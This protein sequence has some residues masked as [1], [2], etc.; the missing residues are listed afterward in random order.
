MTA[1]G[2]STSAHRPRSTGPDSQDPTNGGIQMDEATVLTT[3]NDKPFSP[4]K[5]AIGPCL[6]I[7]PARQNPGGEGSWATSSLSNK[8]RGAA[9]PPAQG[10]RARHLEACYAVVLRS[11][12]LGTH[13]PLWRPRGS[14]REE[15]REARSCAQHCLPHGEHCCRQLLPSKPWAAAGRSLPLH[16]S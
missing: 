7:C 9:C 13:L 4:Q 11:Y 5:P 10:S 3:N 16:T 2:S 12:H 6:V 8:K 14:H 1:R 15:D